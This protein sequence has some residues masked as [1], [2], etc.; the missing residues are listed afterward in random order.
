LREQN[1]GKTNLRVSPLH[2]LAICFY[3]LSWTRLYF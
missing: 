2:S 1:L 3:A